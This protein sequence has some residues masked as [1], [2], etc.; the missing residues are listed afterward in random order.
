MIL[1][2]K[3][4]CEYF[5]TTFKFIFI[6]LRGVSPL[7]MQRLENCAISGELRVLTLGL[8]VPYAYPAMCGIQREAKK[9]LDY[10]Y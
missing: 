3:Q 5:V 8:Q 4:Y 1:K 10:Y 7:D 6:S 9:I 2:E